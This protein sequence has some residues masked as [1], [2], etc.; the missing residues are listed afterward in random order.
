[1]NKEKMVYYI[2][3]AA[4]A[5]SDDRYIDERLILHAT[6]IVRGE[7]LSKYLARRPG[8]SASNYITNYEV[9]LEPVTRSRS[10]QLPLNC[11]VLRST[12]KVPQLLNTET[13]GSWFEVEPVDILGFRFDKIT[14]ANAKH[15][16]FEFNV[17]KAFI[18]T[19]EYLYVLTPNNTLDLSTVMVIG[20]FSFPSEVNPDNEDYPLTPDLFSQMKPKI[21]AELLNKP[22][23]D[24]LNNS[25]KDESQAKQG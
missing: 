10:T 7:M 25:E 15:T 1:M 21:V 16:T 8:A 18:S 24:I 2:R 20:V 5:N 23:E 17:P 9:K 4:S 13:L 22:M 14:E 6:D 12:E 3:E 19:D 11:L